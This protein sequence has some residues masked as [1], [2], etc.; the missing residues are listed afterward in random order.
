MFNPLFGLMAIITL[1]DDMKHVEQQSH[2]GTTYTKC[3]YYLKISKNRAM[4]LRVHK[5]LLNISTNVRALLCKTLS[6]F[7]NW[8]KSRSDNRF[9]RPN[10]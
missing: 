2:C 1:Q 6:P 4:L 3:C 7:H 9:V 10:K 5:P 8:R